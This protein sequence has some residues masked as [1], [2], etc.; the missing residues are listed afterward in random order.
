MVTNCA[1]LIAELS[2]FCYEGDSMLFLSD[3]NQANAV[4]A[5]NLPQDLQMTCLILIN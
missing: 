2:L 3:N 1:P 4:E 5:F